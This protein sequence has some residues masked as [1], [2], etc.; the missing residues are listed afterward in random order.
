MG[1]PDQR[2]LGDLHAFDEICE[3]P[4]VRDMAGKPALSETEL[5]RKSHVE[6][7]TLSIRQTPLANGSFP[8][9]VPRGPPA[10][11]CSGAQGHLTRSGPGLGGDG[12]ARFM[13]NLTGDSYPPNLVAEPTARH[14]EFTW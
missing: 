9:E 2:D 1:C 12:A 3:G 10:T 4:D 8:E 14:H 13:W 11:P 7:G 6:Q 5:R